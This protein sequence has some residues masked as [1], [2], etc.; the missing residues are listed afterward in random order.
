MKDGRAGPAAEAPGLEF[1]VDSE[2][3]II[4]LLAEGSGIIGDLERTYAALGVSYSLIQGIAAPGA[5]YGKMGTR[6]RFDT[7]EQM[8]AVYEAIGKFPYV[9]AAI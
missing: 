9:K 7:R 4:Y 6:L 3:R 5:K 2:I 1:P 8:Y